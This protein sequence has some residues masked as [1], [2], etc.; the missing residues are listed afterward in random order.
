MFHTLDDDDDDDDNKSHVS[1]NDNVDDGDASFYLRQSQVSYSQ[2]FF[3]TR[4]L[5]GKG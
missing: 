5:K 4:F 2:I 3:K 1:N